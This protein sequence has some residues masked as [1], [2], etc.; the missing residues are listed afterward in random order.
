MATIFALE[1]SDVSYAAP[2][3]ELLFDVKVVDQNAGTVAGQEMPIYIAGDETPDE[4]RDAVVSQ[5][6]AQIAM[7][8]PSL[9]VAPSDFVIVNVQRGA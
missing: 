1:V 5:L 7:Y 4:F 2:L 8:F 3:I 9:T 6:T